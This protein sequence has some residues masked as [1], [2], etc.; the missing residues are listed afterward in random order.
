MLLRRFLIC[1]LLGIASVS[2]G[3]LPALASTEY[4]AEQAFIAENGYPDLF[5]VLFQTTEV[6]LFRGGQVSFNP[7][8]RTDAWMYTKK[9]F[10]VKFINGRNQGIVRFDPK[11]TAKLLPSTRLVPSD[12][13][14]ELTKQQ[15]ENRFGKPDKVEQVSFFNH[16]MEAY[17]YLTPGR[18]V[19]TFTFLDNKLAGVMAGFALIPRQ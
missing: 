1:L 19:K 14:P 13:V 12:F 8:H 17:R 9:G 4:P 16:Q 2:M 5:M 18:G 3:A 15:I 11:N 7:P 6:D 10:R